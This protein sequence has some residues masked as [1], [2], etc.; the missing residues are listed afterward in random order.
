MSAEKTEKKPF[1]YFKS[2]EIENIKCFKG[3][4]QIDLTDKEG[5]PAKWTVIMGNNGTGKTTVLR[6]LADLEPEIIDGRYSDTH[7]TLLGVITTIN[8]TNLYHSNYNKN[9]AIKAVYIRQSGDF[10]FNIEIN[11][12]ILNDYNQQKNNPSNEIDKRFYEV[13]KLPGIN[14]L[15]YGI[16]RKQRDTQFSSY[17]HIKNTNN[18]KLLS[19]DG[20]I[21]A[22]EWLL[23]ISFAFKSGVDRAGVVLEK[24][25]KLLFEVLPDIDDFRIKTNPESLNSYVEFYTNSLWVRVNDLGYGYQSLIAWLVDFSKSMIEEYP[26][27]V[28]PLAE[29]AVVLVDEIALHL[30]PDWQRDIISFLDNHFPKTQ[31][32]VTT[33]SPLVIQSAENVNLVILEKDGEGVRISQPEIT[34][35]QGWSI[36]EI[37]SDIMGLNDEIFSDE[38]LDLMKKFE[39]ALDKESYEMAKDTYDKLDKILHPSST[40]RTLM[41]MQMAGI[42]PIEA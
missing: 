38:Y 8:D 1:A 19:E 20:L 28:N 41:K 12:D 16:Y 31:F 40:Q 24:I 29:P 13:S 21:N 2:L 3:K 11:D 7:E 32:I 15:A 39:E 14:F 22:E 30:H 4:H 35:L 26:D 18:V 23:R 42:M 33:H 17:S 27:S 25:K 9:F 5:K 37:M 6:C 10:L 34:N 36:E